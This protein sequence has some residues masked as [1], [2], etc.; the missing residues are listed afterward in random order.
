[1]YSF[2]PKPDVINTI[3]LGLIDVSKKSI[4]LGVLAGISQFISVRLSIP[5]HV[6]TSDKPSFKDDLAKSMNMQMRYIMPVFV[7][8]ISLGVSGAV[9]LYWITSNIFTIGQELYFRKTVKAEK[10]A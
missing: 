3:F 9:S 7:F 1:L 10:K 2:V 8:F 4:I 5:P 6:P